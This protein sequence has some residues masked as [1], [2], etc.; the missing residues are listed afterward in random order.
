MKTIVLD[1]ETTGKEPSTDE[2]LQVSI[3]DGT[4]K[5]LFNKYIKPSKVT[6][7]PEAEK[8]NHISPKKVKNCKT[9]DYYLPKLRTIIDRA[10]IIV[11][12]NHI[13]FDIPFLE[14]AGLRFGNKKMVD[15][16]L[17][18]RER[19]HHWPK[20]TEVA[21]DYGYRFN[22]HNSLEDCKATLYIFDKT[23]NM[24]S[25]T[26]GAVSNNMIGK[27]AKSIGYRPKASNIP[28]LVLGL[29]VIISLCKLLEGHIGENG[30]LYLILLIAGLYCYWIDTGYVALICPL[31]YLLYQILRGYQSGTLLMTVAIFVVSVILKISFFLAK[32]MRNIIFQILIGSIGIIISIILF[33]YLAGNLI[34]VKET[35]A[36]LAYTK[37]MSA[38]TPLIMLLLEGGFLVSSFISYKR[39]H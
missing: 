39:N 18:Q 16:F 15:V 3:I 32:K 9:I 30:Q 21:R 6:S 29:I 36:V 8:V 5:V 7:W 27:A 14:Q 37:N 31:G 38:G 4:G 1:L 17:E 23:H 25:K 35:T 22:P 28:I 19:Y 24:A 2:I 34:G 33:Q 11:G 13:H 12:Y 20:L 10:D 26:K